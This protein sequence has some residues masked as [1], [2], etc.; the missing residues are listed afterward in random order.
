[1]NEWVHEPSCCYSGD[2][3]LSS[4]LAGHRSTGTHYQ[5]SNLL[6]IFYQRNCVETFSHDS[7]AGA[8]MLSRQPWEQKHVGLATWDRS[9][10]L[11]S[12]PGDHPSHVLLDALYFGW[13]L[14]T[15]LLLLPVRYWEKIRTGWRDLRQKLNSSKAVHRHGSDLVKW[16]SFD[17]NTSRWHFWLRWICRVAL[18]KTPT[19][20]SAAIGQNQHWNLF[21]TRAA[22][23]SDCK[24]CVQPSIPA[25]SPPKRLPSK[26]GQEPSGHCNLTTA[27]QGC[28]IFHKCGQLFLFLELQGF[29]VLCSESPKCKH[30]SVPSKNRPTCDGMKP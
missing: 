13:L 19:Q 21:T 14:L 6:P 16:Y 22:A 2:C 18:S 10:L 8:V 23:T 4:L 12:P 1:M 7:S 17:K 24:A 3:Q 29:E 28:C 30:K 9:L 11:P 20:L 15:F 25:G 27:R 5:K 26:A